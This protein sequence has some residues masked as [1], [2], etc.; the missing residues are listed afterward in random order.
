MSIMN[1]EPELVQLIDELAAQINTAKMRL[2]TG[3]QQLL[4]EQRLHKSKQT[5]L[6]REQ[7]ELHQ[8][9]SEL[10][11]R[12]ANLSQ[13]QQKITLTTANHESQLE[14]LLQLKLQAAERQ[15][16]VQQLEQMMD[17]VKE[18]AALHQDQWQSAIANCSEADR[19]KKELQR[20]AELEFRRR[21]LQH[22]LRGGTAISIAQKSRREAEERLH[23]LSD[24]LYQ[25]SKQEKQLTNHLEQ[26][27]RDAEAVQA[28]MSRGR[29]HLEKQL[30]QAREKQRQE[31]ERLR[32]LEIR[33]GKLR[34]QTESE[35]NGCGSLS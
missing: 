27:E 19:Q 29:Q 15:L 2:E 25:R 7:L 22:Q 28:S 33:A 18:D 32:T 31:N 9:Q 35:I 34:E 10:A 1:E 20:V 17:R 14:R 16:H 23:H 30:E 4:T 26:L 11:A 8:L 6:V 5:Q 3:R 12:D 13:L 24:Q 21:Q